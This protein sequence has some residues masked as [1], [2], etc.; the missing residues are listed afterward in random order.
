MNRSIFGGNWF[1]DVTATRASAVPLGTTM[2]HPSSHHTWLRRQGFSPF[3]SAG[4]FVSEMPKALNPSQQEA[5][6]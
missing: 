6:D 1:A 5:T 4:S 2:M 3:P